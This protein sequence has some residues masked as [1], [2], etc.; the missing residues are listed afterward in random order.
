[1]T[2]EEA[3]ARTLQLV[4][5]WEAWLA[6]QRPKRHRRVGTRLARELAPISTEGRIGA[7]KGRNARAPAEETIKMGLD[8]GRNG[9]CGFG[10]FFRTIGGSRKIFKI[11]VD[12]LLNYSVQQQ[13]K[14]ADNEQELITCT[15][16]A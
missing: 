14:E 8:V 4:V 10:K 12:R 3:G 9:K 15:Y 16:T 11:E 2:R 6:A 7:W 1:M 5:R 13:Q